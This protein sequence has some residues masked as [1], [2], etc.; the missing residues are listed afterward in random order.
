MALLDTITHHDQVKYHRPWPRAVVT[1]AGWRNAIDHLAAGRCSLLG[2]WGD[3]PSVH[4]ALLSQDF[5]EIAVVSYV[6]K[7]GTYP[8]VSARHPPAGKLE[9]AIRDLYGLDAVGAPDSRTWLDLGF[10]SVRHPLGKRGKAVKPKPYQ[11]LPVE[12]EGLHQIPVG[13]V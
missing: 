9:R 1:E 10:W 2:L 5:S 11:F 8:S 4:M 12:G 13:P 3:A 6:C 7:G